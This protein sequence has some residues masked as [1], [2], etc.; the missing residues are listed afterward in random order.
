MCPI[1]PFFFS[2]SDIFITNRVSERYS[3]RLGAGDMFMCGLLNI[4]IAFSKFSE[5][6]LRWLFIY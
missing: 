1:E 2:S 3:V 4:F 6:V 5:G